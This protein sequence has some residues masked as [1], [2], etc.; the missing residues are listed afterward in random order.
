MSVLVVDIGSSSV[1]AIL[2]DEQAQPMPGAEVQQ[3]YQFDHSLDGA[4]TVDPS[5]LQSL[6]EACITQLLGRVES[7][8]VAAVGV[9]TF[10]G[11]L[12]G[13]DESGRPVTPVMTYADARSSASV[14]ELRQQVDEAQTIQETGCRIHAAYNTV[15]LYWYQQTY[16]DS[17]R[18]VAHWM[19]FASFLYLQW[20]GQTR[21]SHS[22]ASW[23]GLLDRRELRWHQTW[24]DVLRLE[25]SD[26]TPLG[27]FHEALTGL[28]APY[29]AQ[30]PSLAEVPF[31][32]AVGD[33]AAATVGSGAFDQHHAALTVGS[34]SA[35]RTIIQ[36]G[37]PPVPD[38]LW[39]YRVTAQ[40]HLIGGA[41]TEG[42]TVFA[43]AKAVLSITDADV[44]ALEASEPDGHGLTVLPLFA[45]E[46]SPGWRGQA[47]A[48]I[49]GIRPSTTK[50]DM[51][52]ALLESVALRLAEVADA[53][54]QPDVTVMA[55]GGA[56]AA[57]VVWAQMMADSLARP[58]F[59]VGGETSARG[60][61]ILLLSHLHG[62]SWS[63]FPPKIVDEL[64]PHPP[65]V[66]KYQH[67]R[68]RQRNLYRRLY[69]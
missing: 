27:E 33:G 14:D 35:I 9:S 58:L 36:Q 60:V 23:S 64:Q 4:V 20:F 19:D 57:S 6:V 62:S 53:L 59:V 38:G 42:G 2:F 56:L 15:K 54:L 32:L 47:S 43:W 16:P 18:H 61:A 28:R 12:M 10:V 34:T 24:L 11:N 48:T 41:T 30:W 17:F 67:A 69:L 25:A 45:G 31:Y 29:V 49:H 39:G 3:H 52:Q 22:A 7:A 44:S 51:L 40:H 21:T 13:V 50:G 65:A 63:D 66:E 26:L 55:S 8:S 1:R 68:E 37:L 5:V 46:R